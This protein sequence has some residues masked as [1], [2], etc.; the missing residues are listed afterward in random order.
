M[1]LVQDTWTQWEGPP[2]QVDQT[3]KMLPTLE[4]VDEDH[5]LQIEQDEM[6]VPDSKTKLETRC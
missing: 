6:V 2:K 3:P 1:K 4:P 5:S